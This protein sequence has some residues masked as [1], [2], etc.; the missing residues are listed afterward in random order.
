ML[1]S[2]TGFEDFDEPER[3]RLWLQA[4]PPRPVDPGIR[5]YYGED[6]SHVDGRAETAY[7][8]KVAGAPR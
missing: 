6:G 2:R 3:K 1:H 7:V 5:L 4:H 8:P